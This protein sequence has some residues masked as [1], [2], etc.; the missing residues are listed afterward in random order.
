[1]VHVLSPDRGRKFSPKLSWPAL[2]C[3]LFLFS[4]YQASF[5]GLKQSGCE[6]D[7]S[8]PSSAKF[9]N[10]QSYISALPI[11]VRGVDRDNVIFT[12]YPQLILSLS[13]S[14]WWIAESFHSSIPW[15]SFIFA[16][17]DLDVLGTDLNANCISFQPEFFWLNMDV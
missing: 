3:T 12:F 10:E 15:H 6:I 8:P 11:C 14:S 9:M 5:P 17:Q 16:K 4:Q 7:D 2:G 1:M 13:S